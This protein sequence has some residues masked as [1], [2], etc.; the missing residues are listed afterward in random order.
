MLYQNQKCQAFLLIWLGPQSQW[1]SWWD[2]APGGTPPV[3]CPPHSRP[4]IAWYPGALRYTTAQSFAH[5]FGNK[6]NWIQ[7]TLFSPKHAWDWVVSKCWSCPWK[8]IM[9]FRKRSHDNGAVWNFL[10]GSSLTY[11]SGRATAPI[12]PTI[13]FLAFHNIPVSFAVVFV[14]SFRYRNPFLPLIYL[15]LCESIV[16]KWWMPRER[17]DS[18]HLGMKYRD[19]YITREWYT[20][21]TG[22]MG[23]LEKI[24]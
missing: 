20:E 21:M 10:S 11:R 8:W 5:L 9:Q 23:W 2:V 12:H 15:Q 16:E 6:F 1:N 24:Q 22:Q 17:Y 4:R 14:G 13:A 18:S 7:W 19:I 3:S